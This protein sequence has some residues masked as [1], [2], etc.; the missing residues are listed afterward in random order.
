MNIV[1]TPIPNPFPLQEKGDYKFK[2]F[3]YDPKNPFF[4]KKNI[5]YLEYFPIWIK[6]PKN[7]FRNLYNFLI[8]IKTIIWSDCVVIWWGW[9]IYD[10]ENQSVGNPLNQWLFRTNITRLFRKKVIFYWVWVDIT[11][12]PAPLLI[13]EGSSWKKV[14]KIFSW[15]YKIYV[16]DNSSY[17][18]LRDLWLESEV[19]LDPVFNDNWAYERNRENCIKKLNSR[20]F[21]LGDIKDIDLKNKK[22]WIAFRSGFLKTSPSTPLLIGEGSNIEELNLIHELIKYIVSAW[23]E[24]ILLPHSF[25]RTDILANDYEFLKQFVRDWV[26]IASS[27][28]ETYDYY[29]QKKLDICLAQRLHSMIL[30]EV[31][32]IPFVWFVYG[33]KTEELLKT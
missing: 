13:G 25:H 26:N 23:W 7:I 2:V 30:S 14:K 21:K 22:V 12:P 17:E 18:L 32:N 8:F 15:A 27:M 1:N 19:I 9:I 6:N 28:Q 10:N 20:D 4:E 3:S 11:S 33:K 16:R 29:V 5:E 24:V 31:Y